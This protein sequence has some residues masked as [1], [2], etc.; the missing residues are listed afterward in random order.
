MYSHM[1]NASGDNFF[2]SSLKIYLRLLGYVRPY[3]RPFALSVLGFMLFAAGQPA[4]AWV[5]KHFI[6][7]L[8]VGNSYRFLGVPLYWGFPAFIVFIAIFQ[9]I[10][11]F[12]GNYSI[13][14]VS[15]S[16]VHDLRT[17]MFDHMLL[18]PDHF[19]DRQNSGHLLTRMA[20]NVNMVTGAATEAIKII[21]REGLTVLFLFLYLMWMNWKLTAVVILILPVVG[22]LASRA[23]RKFRKQSNRMQEA[24]GD[25]THVIT[26]AISGHRV[27]RSYGGEEYESRRFRRASENSRSRSLKMTQTSSVYTPVLQLVTYSVLAVMMFLVLWLR[28]D[29]SAGELVSYVTAACLM[30][31]PIKQLSEVSA[32]MQT[33]IAAAE[34]LFNLL[35]EAPE[36][37]HGKHEAGRVGGR[38][39]VRNLNFCYPGTEKQVLHDVSFTAEPGQMIALVGRSGSGKS[40]LA[41]LIPRFYDYE[42]GH[43]LLDGVDV[44]EYRLHSLRQQVALVSQQVTL[45]N[46]TVRNNIAYGA[47]ANAPRERIEQAA[48]DAYA[49]EFI[50]KLPQGYDTEIGDNGVLLS[51]GQRQ[52]LA[53]ARALLK[54][55]PVLILDEATSALDT[56]S[57]RYIQAAL[58]RA[59]AGRTTLVIAHRL[60]TIEKADLILVMDHGRIVERGT[61]AELIARGGYYAKLHA[62]GLDNLS[63][64]SAT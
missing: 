32:T 19:I 49:S 46:D 59:V 61:H 3:W 48:A 14:K 6:D 37:D 64:N 43:I 44:K 33:G 28:G 29:A 24:M 5:F 51:G 50:D 62:M 36:A 16:V 54:D 63:E 45:F 58:D 56:E 57:E 41:S 4:M 25:I 8:V 17:H 31:K 13:S 2:S 18:L 60:S 11:S 26:E 40:T 10:G 52:R 12:L 55:A 42:N 39:D 30:P 53:I 1:S 20:F 9:G 21:F 15:L 7:G 27:V 34:N 47:L 23:S 22:V 35:D 38:I